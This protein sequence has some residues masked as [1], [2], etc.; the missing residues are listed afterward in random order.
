MS[1]RYVC[2]NIFFKSQH[3]DGLQNVMLETF[4]KYF[5]NLSIFKVQPRNA[6]GFA[7]KNIHCTK[8]CHS[9]RLL[10]L[11]TSFS[12]FSNAIYKICLHISMSNKNQTP[13]ISQKMCVSPLLYNKQFEE[14]EEGGTEQTQSHTAKNTSNA[15]YGLGDGERAW[16]LPFEILF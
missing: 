11:L 3:L 4:L 12:L 6:D 15:V 13:T 5:S 16:F 2:H 8:K 9:F 7:N 14:C 1:S 10:S